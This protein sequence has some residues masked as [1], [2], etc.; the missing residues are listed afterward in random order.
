MG[1][2]RVESLGSPSAHSHVRGD[3]TVLCAA[4][5]RMYRR[6]ASC[7]LTY[8]VLTI[9]TMTAFNLYLYYYL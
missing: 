6:P 8:L 2:S 3:A 4:A 7:A 1:F 9:F 5:P